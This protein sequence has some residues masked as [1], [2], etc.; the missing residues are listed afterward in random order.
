MNCIKIC[1]C[2]HCR[3]IKNLRK[4]RKLK[5]VVKRLMNKRRRRSDD[6]KI[7]NWYWA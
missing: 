5:R 2:E 1:T 4:N 3:A 6:T 7:W